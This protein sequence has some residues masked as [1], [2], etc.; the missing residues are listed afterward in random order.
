PNWNYSDDHHDTI[1]IELEDQGPH[2][3]NNEGSNSPSIT[4][5]GLPEDVPII[6]EQSRAVSSQDIN[7]NINVIQDVRTSSR[8][9][10]RTRLELQ[11][12]EALRD[13][14]ISGLTEQLRTSLNES[15]EGSETEDGSRTPIQADIID[16]NLNTSRQIQQRETSQNPMENQDN[17]IFQFTL[18][19][20]LPARIQNRDLN[21]FS[22][23]SQ[24]TG[25]Q[26]NND[27]NT[28]REGTNV[29]QRNSD[30]SSQNKNLKFTIPPSRS[31]PQDLVLYASAGDLYL[32]DPKARLE[33][34]HSVSR[35]VRQSDVRWLPH[36]QGF[37]R[38][39][40]MECIPELSLAIVASQKGKVALVRLLRVSSEGGNDRYILQPEKYLPLMQ[41][42]PMEPLLGMCV[43]KQI[44][45]SSDPAFHYYRLFLLYLDG[46]LCC[47]EI[48]RDIETNPSYGA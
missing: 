10:I 23:N 22:T 37:D 28:S 33:P 44:S 42:M 43:S 17:T 29:N 1:F 31:L 16:S 9:A 47:Y 11:H 4:I 19:P 25:E 34:L 3:D 24:S 6:P 15:E 20:R 38:L 18:P 7:D 45:S 39:N 36:L 48:S 5:Q 27:S 30:S 8:G 26:S 2:W 13:N 12:A 46:N 14:D 40:M 41:N 32:L 35:I 21:V